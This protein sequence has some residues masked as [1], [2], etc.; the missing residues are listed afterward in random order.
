LFRLTL[1][2]LLKEF[3]EGPSHGSSNHIGG[4]NYC[5]SSEW[6]SKP[7]RIGTGNKA[8][9]YV[10]KRLIYVFGNPATFTDP[11]GTLT[12]EEIVFDLARNKVNVN[13][14]SGSYKNPG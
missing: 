12:G 11:Q 13:K 7:P 4:K 2:L 6:L 10:G 3:H 14:S 8:T 9:Y 1:P 5:R